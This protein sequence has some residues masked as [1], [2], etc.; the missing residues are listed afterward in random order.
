MDERLLAIEMVAT[1][2]LISMSDLSKGEIPAPS[3]YFG[4]LLVFSMLSLGAMAGPGAAQWANAFGGL[5]VLVA[6]MRNTDKF[7]WLARNLKP[8]FHF[9]Q[10]LNPTGSG[11]GQGV[12]L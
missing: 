2:V 10:G 4:V 5:V 8:G 6:A 3:Q 9:P 1:G 11:P 12:A 7:V